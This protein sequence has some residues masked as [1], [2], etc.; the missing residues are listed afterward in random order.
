MTVLVSG[1]VAGG[2]WP[3]LERNCLG[4]GGTGGIDISGGGGGGEKT[5]R[6]GDIGAPVKRH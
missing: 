5:D 3:K 2:L 6:R 4:I 1:T